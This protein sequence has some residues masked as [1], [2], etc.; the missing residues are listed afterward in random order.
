MVLGAS[1][2]CEFTTIY[3]S[4]LHKHIDWL[5][6]IF[7]NPRTLYFG[8]ELQFHLQTHVHPTNNRTTLPSHTPIPPLR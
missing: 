8:Q 6:L 1:I 5:L 3:Q 4:I 2:H 7:R